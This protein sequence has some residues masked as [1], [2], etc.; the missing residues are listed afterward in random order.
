MRGPQP[1]ISNR[2][3]V[4]RQPTVRAEMLLWQQLRDRRLGSFKFVRQCPVGPYFG[5][6]V[7]R[8]R[9]LIVEVD[10]GTHATEDEIRSD[11]RRTAGLHRLGY[12][13]VR[14][15]N[16]DVYENI[17]GVLGL[18]LDALSEPDR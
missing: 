10:G 1:W 8:E 4:L 11:V 6:F 5:D 17:Q 14:V 16:S 3:R 15:H 13:I 9:R 7:C 18:V 2:A 12:P